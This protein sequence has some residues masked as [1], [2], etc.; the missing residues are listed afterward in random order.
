MLHP[1]PIRLPNLISSCCVAV[2]TL[3]LAGAA[4]AQ[5]SGSGLRSNSVTFNSTVQ[6]PDLT[7]AA[8]TYTFEHVRTQVEI[9]AVEVWS[10]TPKKLI[11]RLSTAPATRSAAGQMVTFRETIAK[12]VPAIDAW[13][14]NGGTAGYQFI[15]SRA[16][17]QAF[18]AP[19]P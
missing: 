17:L 16:Q 11:G 19:L 12:T 8:G 15:Y 5:T 2:C 13:Y 6:L 3:M 9:G 4:G 7:L 14:M 18:G 10:V 1:S